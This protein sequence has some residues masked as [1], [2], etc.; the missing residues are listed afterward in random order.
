MGEK[1]NIELEESKLEKLEAIARQTSEKSGKAVSV[2]ELIGKAIDW[3]LARLAK[4]LK[5]TF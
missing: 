2:E 5:I 1:I 4:E 3:H